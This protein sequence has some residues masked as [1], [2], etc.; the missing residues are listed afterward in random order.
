MWR[1]F[2]FMRRLWARRTALSG[3]G[4][5]AGYPLHGGIGETGSAGA[6]APCH[7]RGHAVLEQRIT[8][9]PADTEDRP[10]RF[11]A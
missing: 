10:A 4:E 6:K 1:A 3:I 2:A 8:E 7:Q 5:T 11:P 9:A